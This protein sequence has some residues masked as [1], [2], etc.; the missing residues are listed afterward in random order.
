MLEDITRLMSDIYTNYTA[1]N[2]P[3]QINVPSQITKRVSKDL[4]HSNR[5]VLPAMEDIFLDAQDN[6][7]KLLKSD[8]YPRFVKYQITASAAQALSDDTKRYAGLGDCF[9]L[10]DPAYVTTI[11]PL[12]LAKAKTDIIKS[13]RQSHSVCL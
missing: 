12:T 7:E 1:T 13:S 10:T 2:A 8:I 3:S 9:C 4:K 5:V 11:Y 6:V